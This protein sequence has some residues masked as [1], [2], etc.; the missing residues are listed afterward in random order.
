MSSVIACMLGLWVGG[1]VGF[2]VAAVL[3]SSDDND[4]YGN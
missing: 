4:R 2:L 1:T 3:A